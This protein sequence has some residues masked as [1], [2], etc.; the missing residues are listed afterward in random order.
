GHASRTRT[1]RPVSF[2][3]GE[4]GE[5]GL[6]L[7]DARWPASRTLYRES[8]AYHVAER[9]PDLGDL[10]LADRHGELAATRQHPGLSR[11]AAAAGP[12]VHRQPGQ[13]S[14]TLSSA[15]HADA[16]V[17]QEPCRLRPPRA[18]PGLPWGSQLLRRLFGPRRRPAADH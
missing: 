3:P 18:L 10:L 13:R 5:P 8:V 17:E 16:I 6:L 12:A 9:P 15:V 7:S 11:F 14:G 4:R 2:E 1:R